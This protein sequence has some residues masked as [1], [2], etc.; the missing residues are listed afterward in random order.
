MRSSWVTRPWSWVRRSRLRIVV[1]A[2]VALSAIA[3]GAV[4]S[5]A[6]NGVRDGVGAE[7]ASPT[8]A[9][10]SPSPTAFETY[11]PTPSRFETAS[12]SPTAPPTTPLPTA[13]PVPT[14]L[15]LTGTW[16]PLPPAPDPA[17]LRAPSA[18]VLPDGG[19]AVL[20]AYRFEHHGDCLV[21]YHPDTESWEV[22]SV[23]GPDGWSGCVGD[24]GF[25]LH[26]DGRLYSLGYVIDPAGGPWQVENAAWRAETYLPNTMGTTTDGRLYGPTNG[27]PP[28]CRAR[29]YELDPDTGAIRPVSDFN[30]H[31]LDFVVRGRAS[32]LYIGESGGDSVVPSHLASYDPVSGEWREEPSAPFPASWSKAALGPGGW[33]YVQTSY[34]VSGEEGLWAREPETG[35]WYEVELPPELHIGWSPAFVDGGD[36]RLYAFDIQR[37]YVFTPAGLA[38]VP[39]V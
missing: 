6:L 36:G 24:D 3:L 39:T 23:I 2:G 25:S 30:G 1:V 19:I 37:P 14:E 15:R 27:C 4:V 10:A 21:V 11:T 28:P 32:R 17:G 34:D 18:V 7:P 20:H 33:I 13:S 38:P 16:Q 5:G 9:A 26:P 8:V 29:L 31:N 35:D 12:P 22:P